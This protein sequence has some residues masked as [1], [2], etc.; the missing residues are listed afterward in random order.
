LLWTVQS[1]AENRAVSLDVYALVR[2]TQY[3][4]LPFRLRADRLQVQK[5][6]LAPQPSQIQ[7]VNDIHLFCKLIFGPSLKLEVLRWL[8]WRAISEGVDHAP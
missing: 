1:D 7:M 5:A 4:L 3:P 2:Q 6:A 8:D